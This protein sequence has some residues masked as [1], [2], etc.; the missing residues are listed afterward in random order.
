LDLIDKKMVDN[1]HIPHL[2]VKYETWHKEV[3]SQETNVTYQPES[4]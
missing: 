2:H 3:V 1:S 4:E